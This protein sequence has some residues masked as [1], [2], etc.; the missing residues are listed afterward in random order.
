MVMMT[1]TYVN[2]C[3][4]IGQVM[5]Q[6]IDGL[7]HSGYRLVTPRSSVTIMPK[8]QPGYQKRY[9][10]YK[11][12]MRRVYRWADARNLPK[13]PRPDSNNCSGI[14]PKYI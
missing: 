7:W 4:C 6:E 14:D 11:K 12:A 10:A 8:N 5:I 1:Y 2:T 3:N 13:G 9:Q